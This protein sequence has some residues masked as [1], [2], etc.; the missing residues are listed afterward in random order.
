MK[1]RARIAPGSFFARNEVYGYYAAFTAVYAQQRGSHE[2]SVPHPCRLES[3]PSSIDG[4][5]MM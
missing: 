5:I 3:E 2:I 4:E 1:K